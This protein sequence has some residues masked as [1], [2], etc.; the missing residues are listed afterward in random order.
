[1]LL[2]AGLSAD[3]GLPD[4]ALA[5]EQVQQDDHEPIQLLCSP[6]PSPWTPVVTLKQALRLVS[7]VFHYIL[8][9]TIIYVKFSTYTV[10]RTTSEDGLGE[11]QSLK[12]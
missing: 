11:L 10:R 6:R 12:T 8:F 9:A 4:G 3:L 7:G 2:L 1:M 5:A